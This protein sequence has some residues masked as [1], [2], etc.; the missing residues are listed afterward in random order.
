MLKTSHQMGNEVEILLTW[1]KSGMTATV[2]T[3]P[4]RLALLHHLYHEEEAA[5]LQ[6]KRPP[7]G[8]SS[9]GYGPHV[10]TSANP[11]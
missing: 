5:T 1:L 6:V 10:T 4:L 3:V 9:S 7:P 8:Y 2:G 11:S